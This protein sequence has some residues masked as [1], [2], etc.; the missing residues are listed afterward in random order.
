MGPQD[1]GARHAVAHDAVARDLGSPNAGSGGVRPPRRRLERKRRLAKA[2][3]AIALGLSVLVLAIT[4]AGF[5]GGTW[6]DGAWAQ[7]SETSN[8]RPPESAVGGPPEAVGGAVPGG[9]L[10]LRSDADL[11][12]CVRGL[13]CPEFDATVSI[14][15]QKAAVL[16]QSEGEIWRAIR[17]GPLPIYGLYA[18]GGVFG[19][20]ILFFLLRGRIRIEH[21][22]AGTTIERFNGLERFGHWLLA[23]SFIIL[24]ISGLNILYGRYVVEGMNTL[25]DPDGVQPDFGWQTFALISQAGK[26]A[27][28]NVAWA[29]MLGLVLVFLMWVRHNIP[30]LIDLK[31]IAKGGGLFVKGVHP[32]S[33]K[34]NA[35]QKVI[36]WATILL[37]AS[38]SLSGIALL[39]PFE[40]AMMGKTFEVLNSIGITEVAG[41]K[42]EANVTPMEEQQYQTIWHAIVSILMIAIIVAHIYIG[43]VGMEGAFDAM[44]SGQVDLN[45][46]KEHHNL[47]I[48][49]VRQA[50]A[51]DRPGRAAATPA[52]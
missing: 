8:V 43:S 1:S 35:G 23:T 44:G 27:H 31:W 2:I 17:N 45:W 30:N 9:S 28:N 40:T 20:L 32:D 6:S 16:V 22:P 36:F 46:A 49:E 51:E 37:G 41:F 26:W 14:P 21:G 10:G 48:D 33:R 15:D 29:F 19:L 24:A 3:A 11:W 47:W 39:F 38:I 50:A 7:Q 52:E 18:L 42:L 13:E 25:V 5:V 34:F 12:R 4:V